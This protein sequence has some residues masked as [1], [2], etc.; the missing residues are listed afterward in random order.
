MNH[1]LRRRK[2]KRFFLERISN[3]CFDGVTFNELHEAA[4]LHFPDWEWYGS[5]VFFER[6]EELRAIMDGMAD[7]GE[8]WRD[9][10]VIDGEG[11]LTVYYP[12]LSGSVYSY[13]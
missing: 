8:I 1:Y 12:S 5:G 13:D 10:H 3:Y 4:T 6:K 7:R 9:V 2:L 11:S